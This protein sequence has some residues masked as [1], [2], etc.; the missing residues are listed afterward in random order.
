MNSSTLLTNKIINHILK[1]TILD[2]KATNALIPLSSGGRNIMKLCQKIRKNGCITTPSDYM[3]LFQY[4]SININKVLTQNTNE[5]TKWLSIENDEDFY[6]LSNQYKKTNLFLTISLEH[7]IIFK[8]LRTS[9]FKYISPTTM[10]ID[11]FEDNLA[12]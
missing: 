11:L 1:E 7:Y 3:M 5:F 6:L 8:W 10:Q 9:N 2:L 4:T 12:A